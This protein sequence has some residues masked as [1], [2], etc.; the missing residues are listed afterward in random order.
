L[1]RVARIAFTSE[2]FGQ[3]Q[4]KLKQAVIAADRPMTASNSCNFRE[5]DNVRHLLCLLT[6][7]ADWTPPDRTQNNQDLTVGLRLNEPLPVSLHNT[8]GLAFVRSRINQAFPV[9][10]PLLSVHAAEHGFEADSLLEV[11]RGLIFQPVVQYYV[12]CG[13]SSQNAV[14]LGFHT[15]IDF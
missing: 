7:G 11:P 9:S 5:I 14:I 15:R 8:I 13:G 6:A 12:N 10:S 3:G 1:L 2:R 4:I